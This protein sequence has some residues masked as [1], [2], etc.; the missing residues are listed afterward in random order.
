MLPVVGASGD[1]RAA[2]LFV[3]LAIAALAALI[4]C[5]YIGAMP[6]AQPSSPIP[7]EASFAAAGFSLATAGPSD[8]ARAQAVLDHWAALKASGPP[9]VVVVTDDMTSGGGWEGSKA[10]DDK[11][12]VVSGLLTADPPLATDVPPDGAVVWPDGSTQAVQ[13]ISA[14]DALAAMIAETGTPKCDGCTPVVVTGAQ[15]TTG[16]HATP[17]GDAL[18]PVW[19]FEFKPADQPLRPITYVA[20]KGALSNVNDGVPGIDVGGWGP[21]VDDLDSAYGNSQSAS[22]TVSFTGAPYDGSNPCGADYSA[23]AVESDIAVAVVITESHRPGVST[24]GA[25]LS[26]ARQRSAVAQLSRPL[27]DRVVLQVRYGTPVEVIDGPA[28]TEHLSDD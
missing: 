27:G 24:G 18:L 4:G 16:H 13:L 28:P 2:P 25:C 19:Q 5:Q 3:C 15:L 14:A 7:G 8:L 10:G 12:A 9:D 26:F 17:V 23:T 6:T 20:V 11:V 1:H 21:P 22:L